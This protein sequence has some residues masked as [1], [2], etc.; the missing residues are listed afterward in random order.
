M[1]IFSKIPL[2]NININERLELKSQ[3][4]KYA[5]NSVLICILSYKSL[6]CL[7]LGYMETPEFVAV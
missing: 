6:G 4:H 7:I 5:Y 3:K 2:N 1:L